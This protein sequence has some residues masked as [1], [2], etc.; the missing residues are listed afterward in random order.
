MGEANNS[1]SSVS[2]FSTIGRSFVAGG[3][4]SSKFIAL[5]VT[6]VKIGV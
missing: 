4:S 1:K 3:M 5:P 6:A 2:S